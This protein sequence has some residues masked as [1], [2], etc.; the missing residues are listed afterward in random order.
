MRTVKKSALALDAGGVAD[1]FTVANGPIELLG[2]IA[3]TTEA[4]SAHACD[5]KWQS[6]PTVGASSTDLCGNVD[7]N[8]MAIGSSLYIDGP[9]A[10]AGVIAVNGTAGP[11]MCDTHQVV[12]PG[13]IDLVQ[14]N[15]NPTAGIA[16]VYLVYRPLSSTATVTA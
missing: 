8:A 16:D 6:D 4:V 12:M 7:I 11:E 13:G 3:H 1:V 2:L 5:T 15:S 14:A 10:S 9:S